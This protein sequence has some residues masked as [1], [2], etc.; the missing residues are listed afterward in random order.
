MDKLQRL[1]STTSPTTPAPKRRRGEVSAVVTARIDDILAARSQGH[2]WT[3]I[4][5]ALGV[6]AAALRIVF[7][8]WKRRNF[9]RRR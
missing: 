9:H 1:I 7:H 3:T 6:D 5:G 8:Y 2:K 4:A